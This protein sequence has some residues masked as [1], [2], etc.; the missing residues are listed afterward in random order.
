MK[1]NDIGEFNEWKNIDRIKMIIKIANRIL[2]RPEVTSKKLITYVTDRKEHDFSYAID[3]TK[4]KKDSGRSL[5]YNS[6]KA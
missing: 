4:L 2:S 3:A 1:P 5:R 6:K